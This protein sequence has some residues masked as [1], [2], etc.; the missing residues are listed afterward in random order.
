MRLSVYGLTEN[1]SYFSIDV[2]DMRIDNYKAKTYY[3]PQYILPS[4]F[5]RFTDITHQLTR[6]RFYPHVLDTHLTHLTNI[7]DQF[8]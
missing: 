6:T 3:F 7:R 4:I 2:L 1:S 8:Q 5:A